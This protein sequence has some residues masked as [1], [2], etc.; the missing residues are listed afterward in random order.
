MIR[1]NFRLSIYLDLLW[2]VLDAAM[3]VSVEFVAVW[4]YLICFFD[5]V[6]KLRHKLYA[7]LFLFYGG[8][9]CQ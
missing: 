9:V 5:C 1:Y 6:M 4:L 7:L 2:L 3:P 8:D